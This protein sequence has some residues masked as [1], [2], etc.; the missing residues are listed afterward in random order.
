MKVL[1][2]KK[3]AGLT[4]L[5]KEKADSGGRVVVYVDRREDSSDHERGHHDDACQQ[6][7]GMMLV[8]LSCRL[9]FCCTRQVER[10]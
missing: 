2:N 3:K 7:D 4:D 10:L 6:T 1:N 5:D 8:S 9:F